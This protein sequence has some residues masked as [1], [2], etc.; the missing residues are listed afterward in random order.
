MPRRGQPLRLRRQEGYGHDY[1]FIA[2]FVEDHL[3]FHATALNS[4]TASLARLRL[5]LHRGRENGRCSSWWRRCGRNAQRDAQCSRHCSPHCSVPASP[6]PGAPRFSLPIRSHDFSARRLEQLTPA[7]PPPAQGWDRAQW[8]A[9]ALQLNPQLAEERAQVTAAAAAER[10]A[11]EFANPSLDLF[12]EYLTS[13][14]QSG[15]WLYGLSLDFLLRQPGERARAKQHAALETALAQ[16]DL[17]ESIWQVRA[18]LREA[19]LGAR[20]GARRERPAANAAR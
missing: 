16:S 10:T 7:L 8:L 5:I 19:L 12:A 2:S 18:A 9:A 11:A 17:A 3:R 4:R 13:A 15:A 6:R 20:R 14:A 1:Y